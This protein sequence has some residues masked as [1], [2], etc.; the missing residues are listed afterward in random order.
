MN[1]DVLPP[2][3]QMILQILMGKLISRVLTAV[4]DVNVAD[5]LV[6]GPKS[7]ADLAETTDSNEDALYRMLRVLSAFGIFQ[8]NEDRVFANNGA[9]ALLASE[10]QGSLRDMVR[11]INCKPRPGDA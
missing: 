8:E 3:D 4:V 11:W 5:H 6:D 9:S 7:A 1:R 2:P 10:T